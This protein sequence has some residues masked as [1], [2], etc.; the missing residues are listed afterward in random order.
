L[1]LVA[2]AREKEESMSDQGNGTDEP[3]AADEGTKGTINDPLT[4]SDAD[5]PQEKWQ[6]GSEE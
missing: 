5:A 1:Q 3:D 4:R 6:G 2:R